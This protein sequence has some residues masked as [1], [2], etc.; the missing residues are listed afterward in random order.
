MRI[1]GFSSPFSS[2]SYNLV[3]IIQQHNNQQA[4]RREYITELEYKVHEYNV[5]GLLSYIPETCYRKRF[6]RNSLEQYYIDSNTFNNLSIQSNINSNRSAI[7]S[8][9]GSQDPIY[10]QDRLRSQE[11]SSQNHYSSRDRDSSQE[12]K[13]Q[14][15]S[16]SQESAPY[17]VYIH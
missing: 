4:Y 8:S 12:K 11:Y 7:S 3:Y 14:D 13:S 17:L 6:L 16:G 1:F 2:P 9:L 5:H 10:S 15:R